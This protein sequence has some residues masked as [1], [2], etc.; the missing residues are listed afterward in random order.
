[1]ILEK[2][3]YQ[4]PCVAFAS[5]CG[6]RADRA[7]FAEARNGQALASHGDEFAI[8]ANSV[9]SAHCVC[10]RAE[11]A[12]KSEIRERDHRGRVFGCHSQNL[13]FAGFRFAWRRQ[14]KEHLETVKR[15]TYVEFASGL[16]LW[17]KQIDALAWSEQLF[18][19]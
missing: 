8:D 10:A 6:M 5:V 14:G 9:V 2:A 3:I 1:V 16:W 4:Q 17:A 18:E 13:H 7:N 15:R 19:R 12:W 11:E